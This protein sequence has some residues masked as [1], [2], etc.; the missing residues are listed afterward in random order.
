M[1]PVY[2]PYLTPHSLRH[3][4]DAIDSGWLSYLGKYKS[5]ASRMLAEVLGVKHVL[6]T[7]N[8]TAACHLLARALKRFHPE[9]KKIIVPNN[10]YVAAWNA[11][12]YDGNYELLPL[13]PD[14][15]TWN[16]NLSLLPTHLPPDTAILVCH[17]LGS[18]VNV[19]ALQRR[20]PKTVILE[21]NCEGFGGAYEN[22]PA[23][24]VARCSSISF[25]GNKNITSG[26]G[27]AFVT[28]DKEVYL[29]AKKLH[30]QGQSET[31]Y[32]HDELGYNYRMTNIQA[33]LLLGQME[34]LPKIMEIKKSLFERYRQRLQAIP[35]V[36]LQLS[37]A[38]TE[39]ANWIF[40][41]KFIHAVSTAET[42]KFFAE[43]D[44]DTRPMFAPMTAHQHLRAL[45]KE[46]PIAERLAL[47][48]VML[49]SYPEITDDEFEQVVSTV[50]AYARWLHP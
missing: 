26:E 42:K 3:A 18:I 15:A 8:G 37:E 12:I 9:V 36:E 33:A 50:G 2:K 43:H 1:I 11:F 21:D 34:L 39:H 46:T 13:E 14:T 10:A 7:M 49:P 19:P 23:G 20:Y 16:A 41:V 30:E 6:L 25:F 22:L 17:N 5:E 35:G 40:A 31:K 45:C 27:G 32:V 48:C 38:N 29:Y 28:N 24:T 44:I 4:H 47:Q